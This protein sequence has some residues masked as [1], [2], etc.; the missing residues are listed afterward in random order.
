METLLIRADA[1]TEI[2]NGHVMRCLA[3]AQAWQDH[4]GNVT[5]LCAD[6]LPPALH[7]RLCDE[8]MTVIQR[9]GTSG[10][11]TDAQSVIDLAA[12]RST[13]LVVVD[14]YV[15]G[16]DYQ[17]VLKNADLRVLFLDDNGHAEHYAADWVLNQNIHADESLY[18]QREADTQLLLGTRYALLRREFWRWRGWQRTIPDIA[19]N[20]LVTM[21]GADPDNV[22]LD[23]LRAIDS[24][25][26]ADAL[27]IKV[28]VGASNPHLASLTAFVK[29]S[30]LKFEILTNVT[31]MPELMAWADMVISA[32]GSTV[33]ELCL[34]GVPTI[35]LILADN[36]A[37]LVKALAE[38]NILQATDMHNLPAALT[39]LIAN[40]VERQQMRDSAR[41]LVDG[42]GTN[43]VVMFLRGERLWLREATLADCELIWHWA[44]DP[45]VRQASFSPDP[46]PWESHQTWFQKAI[47]NEHLLIF[48]A[49]DRNEKPLGQLRYLIEGDVATVSISL[50]R[51]ARGMGYST[52]LL[53][54]GSDRIFATTSVQVQHAFIKPDNVASQRTFERASFRLNAEDMVRGQPSL[55]YVRHRTQ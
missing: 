3:L 16:A 14:G 38:R 53:N 19:Q 48:I 6:S 39:R 23:V 17:R 44:N 29:K 5:F 41:V 40:P 54:L 34:L 28:I 50:D 8:S 31:N 49:M 25:P 47:E 35:A 43:R 27:Q 36:Q 18:A 46:I 42:Y 21:G 45:A 37:A 24:I 2:G 7:E 1:S 11:T 9:Q 12:T 13:S 20:L 51:D 10:D 55:Q 30:R 33:W 26:D 32:G 4:G 52:A 22:T 15:F